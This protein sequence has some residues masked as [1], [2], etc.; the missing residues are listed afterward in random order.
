[1]CKARLSCAVRPL[2][3]LPVFPEAVDVCFFGFGGRRSDG[4]APCM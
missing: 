4:P 1:M 3:L 2:F